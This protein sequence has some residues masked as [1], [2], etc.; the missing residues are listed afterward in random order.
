MGVVLGLWLLSVNPQ[1]FALLEFEC[2]AA[3]KLLL[4]CCSGFMCELPSNARRYPLQQRRNSPHGQKV[5][6]PAAGCEAEAV[7]SS[8]I[9]V[10]L[11]LRGT[12]R[13]TGW[14]ARLGLAG[15]G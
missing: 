5:Q 2:R 9:C 15:L 14:G 11:L 7:A 8:L 6:L 13:V 3:L 4:R 1:R 10:R 12:L